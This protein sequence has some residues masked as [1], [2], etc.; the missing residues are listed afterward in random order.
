MEALLKEIRK[1]T[2]G[3]ELTYEE[4]TKLSASLYRKGFSLTLI[5]KALN[6]EFDDL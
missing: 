6:T 4:K 3:G 5:K 2:R 1:K